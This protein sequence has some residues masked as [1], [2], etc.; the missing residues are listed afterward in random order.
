M[1]DPTDNAESPKAAIG[2]D[3]FRERVVVLRLSEEDKAT[4][5]AEARKQLSEPGAIA[6]GYDVDMPIF[7]FDLGLP[8][9]ESGMQFHDW[10]RK[11]GVLS[12]EAPRL[13]AEFV[14]SLAVML[15]QC[16]PEED[17]DA[18]SVHTGG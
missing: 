18:D 14:D 11:W 12:T 7:C 1:A 13:V 3:V 5:L 16:K 4:L 17:L 10:L 8:L 2:L 15:E 9:P 6:A